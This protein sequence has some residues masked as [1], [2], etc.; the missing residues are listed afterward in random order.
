MRHFTACI[1]TGCER[2]RI[3]CSTIISWLE[4][5]CY[6]I[7]NERKTW[8]IGFCL[9]LVFNIYQYRCLIWFKKSLVRVK[10]NVCGMLSSKSQVL[11]CLFLYML[12]N[13]WHLLFHVCVDI[14]HPLFF[15]C[16]IYTD[17]DSSVNKYL[18]CGW[19]SNGA[20]NMIPGT[21]CVFSTS[22]TVL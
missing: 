19:S 3:F 6:L 20:S 12:W 1:F 22:S 21:L 7:S 9:V 15:L 16:Q 10:E 13:I 8:Q 5:I 4:M 18:V 14:R 2:S 11:C 17:C